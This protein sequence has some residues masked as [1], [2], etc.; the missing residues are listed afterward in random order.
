MR[1]P[2]EEISQLREGSQHEALEHEGQPG[3]P[4]VYLVKLLGEELESRAV[5]LEDADKVPKEHWE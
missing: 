3:P 1:R 5:E 4:V 2:E